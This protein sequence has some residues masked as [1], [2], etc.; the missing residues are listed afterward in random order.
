MKVG[1]GSE[2]FC[3]SAPGRLT[4]SPIGLLHPTHGVGALMRNGDVAL[5]C[6]R[7]PR[8]T[9]SS[10]LAVLFKV[11]SGPGGL[12]GRSAPTLVPFATTATSSPA[13][14]LLQIPFAPERMCEPK[15]QFLTRKLS[16]SGLAGSTS[17]TQASGPEIPS[18]RMTSRN[19]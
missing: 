10:I 18:L 19:N 1:G 2:L 13:L 4:T 8:A 5:M 16:S 6:L 3:P 17:S 9:T 7:M 15:R 14:L 12:Q 11:P